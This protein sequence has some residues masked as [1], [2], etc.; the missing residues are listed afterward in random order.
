M[1]TYF[2]PVSN[3]A[4]SSIFVGLALAGSGFALVSQDGHTGRLPAMGWST[5]NEYECAINET[6]ILEVGE[7]LVSLGLKELGYNYVNIDDC[8]SDKAYPRDNVTGRIRPDY[9]KFPGG[10]KRTADGIHELGLKVGIYGDAGDTTCGGYAG[11]LG[12]EQVDAMTF[13][14]WGIDCKLHALETALRS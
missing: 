4:V 5:W 12:H 2:S 7:L 3:M 11:S 13:A 8:W 9:A 6:V 14:E 10:I 1:P